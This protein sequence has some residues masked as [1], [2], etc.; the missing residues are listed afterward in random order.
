[1]NNPYPKRISKKNLMLNLKALLIIKDCYNARSY[2][3][4]LSKFRSRKF[5]LGCPLCD[6]FQFRSDSE[7]DHC[8][9]AYEYKDCKTDDPSCML[10]FKHSPYYFSA[11]KSKMC[12]RKA[13]N[14][15][16]KHLEQQIK[17]TVDR[18]KSN[19]K[20]PE[21]LIFNDL[22]IDGKIIHFNTGDNSYEFV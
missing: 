3:G 9:W 18:L 6:F 10:F 19:F 14:R 22:E 12:G 4:R 13:L 21:I 15:R 8:I 1:M 20:I 17:W 16:L 5:R 11:L 7:C 2:S